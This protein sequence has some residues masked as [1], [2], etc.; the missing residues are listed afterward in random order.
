VVLICPF[1]FQVSKEMGEIIRLAV[2]Q[3][4]RRRGL[5]TSTNF[6]RINVTESSTDP[7]C[8]QYSYSHIIFFYNFPFC[9]QFILMSST[10][11]AGIVGVDIVLALQALLGYC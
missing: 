2:S 11:C 4:Q 1:V 5:F 10:C 8:G 6:R 7:L 3:A 9:I